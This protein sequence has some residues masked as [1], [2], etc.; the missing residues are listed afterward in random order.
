MKQKKV[1]SQY[2]GK[3][4]LARY[5][6]IAV[7]A[8]FVGAQPAHIGKVAA[9]KR[10]SAGGFQWKYSNTIS[11]KLTRS[12]KGITQFNDA[13][14]IVAVYESVETAAKITGMTAKRIA[15][16]LGSKTGKAGGYIWKS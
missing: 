12:R 3:T 16:A 7:A 10:N 14:D 9:G 15:K 6:S 5:S 11:D 4:L 8:D 1:V 13:G 2:S